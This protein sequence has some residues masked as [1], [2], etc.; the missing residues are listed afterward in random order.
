MA[1]VIDASATLPWFLEDERTAFTDDLLKSFASVEYWAPAV[2]CLELPN[3]LLVAERKRRIA[4]ARRVEALD[5]VLRLR[6]RIDLGK[7]DI[8]A[9]SALAER[10]GLT[11]YDAA[12]L[13]LAL[14]QGLGLVT[15]DADLAAAAVAE[16]VPVSSPGRGTAAQRR[17]SYNR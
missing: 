11:T 17:R 14:R 15:L 7:P 13:E 2:W 8:K 6:I 16:Q 5:Q 12:Y 10:H 1:F 3:G 4:P 9:I